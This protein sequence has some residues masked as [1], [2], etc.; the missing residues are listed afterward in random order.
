VIEAEA[1]ERGRS[2]VSEEFIGRLCDGV[3]CIAK[4][5]SDAGAARLGSGHIA[6]LMQV[7]PPSPWMT[8]G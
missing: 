8:R 7:K 3:V 4:P 5:T 6:L 1:G 2:K